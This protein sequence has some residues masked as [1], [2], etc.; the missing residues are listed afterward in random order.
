VSLSHLD[1]SAAKGT[2]RLFWVTAEGYPKLRPGRK[3]RRQ[4]KLGDVGREKPLSPLRRGIIS[5]ER[6]KVRGHFSG[7]AKSRSASSMRC[8][9]NIRR[10][11]SRWSNRTIQFRGFPA[12][13][14]PAFLNAVAESH[15]GI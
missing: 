5:V 15:N 1:W 11:T 4:T 10:S 8:A 12:K 3:T 6:A 7:G 14:D 9:R 2:S 13:T